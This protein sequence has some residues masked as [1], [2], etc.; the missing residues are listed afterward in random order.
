VN[1]FFAREK[2]T[3]E[4]IDFLGSGNRLLNG[5]LAG[6][7][8]EITVADLD[9]DGLGRES[10]A[11][12]LAGDVLL[13]RWQRNGIGHTLVVHDVRELGEGNLD[14]TMISGSMPRRQGVRESGQ[15]SKS[16]FTSAYAGGPGMT[17]SGEP[18][19]KLGG[20][21]KRFRVTKNVGGYYYH[22]VWN[23]QF[24]EMWKLDG[25]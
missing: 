1:Q 2:E 17:S 3:G 11:L 6:Q 12:Q 24:Q 19:A 9:L 25:T 14:V 18:Y 5:D 10:F 23:V 20:G 13:E 21:L 16:Y 4:A 7:R 22:P 15:A 8:G